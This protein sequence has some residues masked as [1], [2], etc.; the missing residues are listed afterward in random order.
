M[1]R[2]LKAVGALHVAALSSSSS[3]L[4]SGLA[5]AM[6]TAA[7]SS[8][9]SPAAAAAAGAGAASSAARPSGTTDAADST[10]SSTSGPSSRGRDGPYIPKAAFPG[11]DRWTT[12]EEGVEFLPA[13]GFV[14][15]DISGLPPNLHR[16]LRSQLTNPYSVQPFVNGES[17][18]D[19]YQQ[20]WRYLG[21]VIDCD[22]YNYDDDSSWDGGTGEGCQRYLIWAAYVDLEYEGG[23]IGEYQYWDRDDE[24]WDATP[25]KYAEGGNSRC[26]KM[27]CHLDD[28]HFSLLGF[29]KHVSYDDWMEQL[30]KHE[31]FC[32]W[33]T[34]EY[35]FMKGAREAWPQG[36]DY[37]GEASDG[38][39]LYYD[40]K[41]KNNGF[42]TVGLYTDTK[43]VED[44]SGSTSV[45]DILGNL[46]VSGD[47]GSGDYDYDFASM[48]GTF[49][50]S[51]E[52]WDSAFEAWRI[53]QPCLAHDLKNVGYGFD[54]DSMKGEN[55]GIYTYG[56]DDYGGGYNAN[57]ADFDCYDA[58]DYTNVNQVSR[59]RNLK[60]VW[61]RR[62]SLSCSQYLSYSSLRIIA[63]L[64]VALNFM[65]N[66]T[67]H[68]NTRSNLTVHEVHGQN[69]Y[70]VC[71][72][73]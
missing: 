15:H 42:F 63:L 72:L 73:P 12:V 28:T 52:A 13:E 21:F 41:P 16:Q 64:P 8:A 39:T 62:V 44:Y 38:T 24:A 18:Y 5:L 71:H 29:F 40:L 53:C 36:C 56:N 9:S 58:A 33:S 10:T 65:T 14:G 3:L 32:V 25:C 59:E 35:A 60:T 1:K 43:C 49:E 6:T 67:S 70:A 31:G 50:E 34:E 4:P 37:A 2:L 66:I 57:G 45:E 55:Y 61:H 48:Y 17:D 46:L 68:P 26:A 19:E 22:S 54:D 7:A 27:D 20:A 11:R 23:G 30:F 69:E 51:L 47:G